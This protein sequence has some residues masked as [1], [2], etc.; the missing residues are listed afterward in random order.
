MWSGLSTPSHLEFGE[1]YYAG[2]EAR[3]MVLTIEP[4]FVPSPERIL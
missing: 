4:C 2:R 3:F 1:L